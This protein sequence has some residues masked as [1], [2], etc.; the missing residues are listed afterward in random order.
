[1][2]VVVCE[3]CEYT[4]PIKLAL[5]IVVTY[6]DIKTDCICLHFAKKGS[7]TVQRDKCHALNF[8]LQFL[9]PES[10]TRQ[11]IIITIKLNECDD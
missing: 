6:A 11:S 7:L 5:L 10:T 3:I 2:I 4:N 1:M 9:L 8:S